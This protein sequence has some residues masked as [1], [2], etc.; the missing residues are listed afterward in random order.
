MK[1]WYKIVKDVERRDGTTDKVDTLVF[2]TTDKN[3]SKR[4]ENFFKSIMDE[5]GTHQDESKQADCPWR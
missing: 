4:V 1:S 5:V 2:E 3:I